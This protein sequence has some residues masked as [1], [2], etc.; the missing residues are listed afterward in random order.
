M[1]T[2]TELGRTARAAGGRARMAATTAGLI[3][4]AAG[5]A[6]CGGSGGAVNTITLYN[7]Q[8][9]QTTDALVQAFEK[10]TGI[11]VR[12]HSDDESVLADQIVT[13][14]GRSPADVVFTENSP[15]LEYLQSAHLL[16]HLPASVGTTTQARYDST[17]GDWMGITARVSVIVYNPS[18]L[19]PSDLP[20]SVMQLADPRSKGKLALAP[21]E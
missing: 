9:V 13:E 3:A 10:Q 19:G 14:G 1:A 18:L 12:V 16:A 2:R 8:H 6:A 5:L 15:A 11:D 4:V 17:R 7:G 21:G 20:T